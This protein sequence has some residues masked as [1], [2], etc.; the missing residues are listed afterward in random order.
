MR[1]RESQRGMTLL[2]VMMA[3]AVLSMGVL[4]VYGL[5]FTTLQ[6]VRQT[7]ERTCAKLGAIRALEAVQTVRFRKLSATDNSSTNPW[8][9]K[10]NYEIARTETGASFVMPDCTNT[11]PSSPTYTM[12]GPRL[13]S[14]GGFPAANTAFQATVDGIGGC[15]V[16]E[17]PVFPLEPPTGS[18][19]RHAGRIVFYNSESSMPSGIPT[20]A[21][22][23]PPSFGF[24]RL[25]CDGDGA[26]TTTDLRTQHAGAT[27]PCRLRPVR[28]SVDWQGVGSTESYDIYSLLTYRGYD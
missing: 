21:F 14:S 10:G 27:N 15:I 7:R 12:T 22:P 11:F 9:L 16:V 19:R 1:V 17:F 8:V 20:K 26:F 3:V 13:T 25:D 5:N 2:E 23:F 24:T 18:N 28:I 6:Q 4:A